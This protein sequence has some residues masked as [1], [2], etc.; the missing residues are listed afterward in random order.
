MKKSELKQF[1]R[2]VI[3]R[4][5]TSAQEKYRAKPLDNKPLTFSEKVK[6]ARKMFDN[7]KTEKQVIEKYGQTVVN[8]VNSQASLDESKEVVQ[9]AKTLSDKE[10]V[11]RY[12]LTGNNV[13][14]ILESFKK[15]NIKSNIGRIVIMKS[16]R[17]F[18]NSGPFYDMITMQKFEPIPEKAYGY[19]DYPY[20][21]ITKK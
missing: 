4:E 12:S 5:V 9:E 10:I 8:A 13:D 20:N 11:L 7:G 18:Q 3:I 17:S 15:L 16:P 19:L 6:L 21:K 1:I 14:E 2:E